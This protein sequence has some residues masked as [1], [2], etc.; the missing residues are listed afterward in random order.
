MGLPHGDEG[1]ECSYWS[2]VKFTPQT[3]FPCFSFKVAPYKEAIAWAGRSSIRKVI[4]GDFGVDYAGLAVN[5]MPVASSG[6]D[7]QS[8]KEAAHVVNPRY[9]E[10]PTWDT[11]RAYARPK[12]LPCGICR[13]V[14][15]PLA[16]SNTQP[17]VLNPQPRSFNN[18]NEP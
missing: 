16:N 7:D 14:P 6:K 17:D 15:S 12:P 1:N 9:F 13:P 3:K 2:S 8:D 5:M 4:V 11:R 10:T 18:P